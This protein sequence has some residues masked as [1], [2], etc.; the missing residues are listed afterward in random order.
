VSPRPRVAYLLGATALSALVV[1]PAWVVLAAAVVVVACAVDIAAARRAPVV[2]RAAPRVLTQG[3]PAAVT[4][5][6]GPGLRTVVRQPATAELRV[7]P[8]EAVG[9]L[10]GSLIGIRRGR[11]TLPA[12][13]LRVDGPL[14]LG[15]W[16][17]RSGEDAEVLVYPDVPQARRLARAARGGR[18]ST[19]G[20]RRGPLGLGTEFESVRDYQ[21][22]D[23]VRQINWRATQRLG[24]PMSNQYRVE[25]DRD[26]IC[27][28]DCG[29]L[30]AAPL[31]DRTRLDVALDA[32]VA[33]AET[34]D[35]LSDR[36]GA[37]AFDSAVLRALPPRRRGAKAVLT[38]VFDLEPRSVDS[39]YR[40]AFA[41]V[42]EGKRALVVVFTDLV[43]EAAAR[44]LLDAIPVLARRHAVVVASVADDE[45]EE[46]VVS[47]PS[48]LIDVYRSVAAGD[49]L[50]AKDRVVAAL[51]HAGVDVV[52]ASAEAFAAACVRSYVRMKARGAF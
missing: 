37:I 36:V 12:I 39:D 3:V 17:G 47:E 49:V 32:A 27:L 31:G 41:A 9:H 18:L 34:A 19:E 10:G 29:R 20:R 44:P 48:R 16:Y 1:P 28:I 35:E 14:G 26:V 42:S 40:R 52:T 25:R 2:A 13:A 24:R 50:A 43:E 4:L 22:D 51:Q 6:A 45:L 23:D 33:V 38:A 5:D 21:H 46:L 11:H 7:E 8:Q 30:T 15:S